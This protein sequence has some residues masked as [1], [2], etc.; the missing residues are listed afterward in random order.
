VIDDYPAT[1]TPLPEQ[2]FDGGGY[3]F[4]LAETDPPEWAV[5]QALWTVEEGRSDSNCGRTFA[6]ATASTA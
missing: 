6:G 2:A 5:E 3:A 4:V 1:L